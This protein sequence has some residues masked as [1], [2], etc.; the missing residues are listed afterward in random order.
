MYA[1]ALV[2]DAFLATGVEDFQKVIAVT[3]QKVKLENIWLK[4]V[5]SGTEIINDK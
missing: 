2:I 3:V 5:S 1:R 4:A